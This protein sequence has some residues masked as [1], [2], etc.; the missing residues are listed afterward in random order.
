MN[1]KDSFPSVSLFSDMDWNAVSREYEPTSKFVTFP[2]YLA[3]KA[4]EGDC[5]QHIFELAYF[6][7]ALA[8]LQEGE[9]T[10][11][12]EPGIHLNPSACFL[13][14]DHDILK[15]V[16]DAHDG[17]MNI[18]ERPNVLSLFVNDEGEIVFHELSRED[19]DLLQ[20]L[21]EGNLEKGHPA[22][23]SLTEKALIISVE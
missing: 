14:L 3:I 5:P 2:E 23:A 12:D 18:I 20:K 19:L 16:V 7:A 4:E 13:S 6:D 9:F 8:G 17:K 1:L 15:M 21:E 11:P 22:L 10:F